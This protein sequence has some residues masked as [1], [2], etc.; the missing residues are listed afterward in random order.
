MAKLKFNMDS[1]KGNSVVQLV[2]LGSGVVQI[3]MKDEENRNGF[4]Q[5]LMTG[6]FQCYA[7]IAKSTPP[8]SQEQGRKE[9]PQRHRQC[10]GRS[11][12]EP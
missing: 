2:E 9:E 6:L 4:S 8:L 12:G 3:T 1:V 10:S 11:M 5:E 7:M